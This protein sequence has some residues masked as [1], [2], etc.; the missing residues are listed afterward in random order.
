MKPHFRCLLVGNPNCGKSSLFNQ[1][2][3]LYQKTGNFQGVTVERLSGNIFNDS[4]SVEIIDL[5]GAFSLN[6]SSEE[7]MIL[8]KFLMNLEKSDK[9]IFVLDPV[10][11]E[12]SLQFLLQ[13][14]DLGAPVLLVMTMKDVIE[15]KNISIDLAL[16]EKQLGLK[17]SF[18][19]AKNGEG[20]EDLKKVIFDQ[21]NFQVAQRVWKWDSKREKILE[22]IISRIA[23]KDRIG[24]RFIVSNALKTLSGE[25]LQKS[26]PG[27][28]IFP[29]KIQ[30]FIK[31]QFKKSG[32]KFTYQD[33]LIAKSIRI[34]S[35]VSAILKS[36]DHGKGSG[37]SKKIDSVLLHPVSGMISFLIIMAL[38]FQ[39]LFSW[40]EIP[41]DLIENGF[42][43]LSR[44]LSSNLPVGPLSDLVSDG[45][46]KGL[47]SVLVFLPQISLLFLFIGIM[48]ESGYMAR[49]S[50]VMDKIMGKFG[51]SGKSFIP[52]LSSAACAVPAIMGARTI[53]NKSD[54][55]A[56]IL[57]APL[58]MC[59]ARYPVYILVIGAI[60]PSVQIFGIFSLKAVVLFFL[61]MLG[62]AASLTF[63]LLFKR[64]FFKSESS[65][66]VIE[67][68]EYKFPSIRNLLLNTYKK[69]KTF[70]VN[71]GKIILAVS[72]ILWFLAN[73][74]AG[75][76]YQA[77]E[78]ILLEQGKNADEFRIRES[79]A[80]SFGNFIEPAIRPL[81][82]DWKMGIALL[83]SFIAREVMVSTLAVI[84]GVEGNEE[85]SG[86]HDAMRNDVNETTGKKVWTTLSAISL[87]VFFAF[88]CQCMSTLAVVRKETNSYFWP[89]FLFS[90]MSVLA[91][92]SSLAVYQFGVFLGFG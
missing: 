64:T 88:A 72:I 33:E 37:F 16:L 67:L 30:E 28:D 46:M 65:Y 68:P 23:T 13:I 36:R 52:L 49:A 39:S 22:G 54:R 58:V 60:F 62:L 48:E 87:L 12:R 43:F 18:V 59:S 42:Q 51:L 10:L 53:E 17:I 8:S 29:V 3:G 15:K 34:K 45:V 86:L 74:P 69:M 24:I 75:P 56:T 55:L 5:P 57:V 77:K 14:I 27:L 32:I 92:L 38:V 70:L 61:F 1:L 44:F 25:S 21:R 9:I 73:Y 89:F 63:A 11:I 90:Y 40:S 19:N 66:F 91:Y 81:G 80:G 31:L 79:F 84:Y 78:S 6:G 71:T 83:T 76:K 35:I 50:F 47:G 4:G 41:M 20:L 85:S 26:L 82:F 2:T 7:K